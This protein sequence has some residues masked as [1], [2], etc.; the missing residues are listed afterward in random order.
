MKA[1]I[2][3]IFAWLVS[4]GI[5][6]LHNRTTPK[7][8]REEIR[9]LR[10]SFSQFGEDIA[11]VRWFD[12]HF[13]IRRGIYVD[14]GAF[15]P[16][17]C[18]NTLLLH[19]NGWRGV[20]I[21]MNAEKIA[22][23]NALRPGDLNVHAAVSNT[24]GSATSHRSGLVER[25][26]L[27]PKGSIPVRRLDD[28]LAQT[29]FREI[30]YLNID[31]EGHDFEVLQSIDLEQY[32]PKIITIEVWEAEQSVPLAEYLAPK[33]YIQKEQLHYTLLFVKT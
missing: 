33:G 31:C 27:D 21:D 12:E 20:N 2:E 9:Y 24:P 1:A 28:I 8:S 19:K 26:V 25:M 3:N 4:A 22:R 6:R 30:D 17:H 15:H 10:L 14:V 13:K 29:A 23:F 5:N 18:S 32:R 11:L 7:F 16:V